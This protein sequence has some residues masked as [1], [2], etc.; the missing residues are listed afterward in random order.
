MQQSEYS[1]SLSPC[2]GEPGHRPAGEGGRRWFC[3][4]CGEIFVGT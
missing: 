1:E 4:S 2:C 3:M